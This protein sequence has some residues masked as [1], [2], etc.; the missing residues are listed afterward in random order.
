MTETQ[1]SRCGWLLA[2]VLIGYCALTL[3]YSLLTPAWEANDEP[4]HTANAEHILYNLSLYPLELHSEQPIPNRPGRMQ[5]VLWFESH[6]P[7]L[8]YLLLAG[9]Q[10][11]LGIPA[12]DPYLLPKSSWEGGDPVG[13][14]FSHD[15]DAHQHGQALVLRKLRLLSV[16]IGLVTVLICYRTASLAF[17]RQDIAVSAAAF[18]AFL[19]KF[20][21][22]N[23]TVTNDGLAVMF[24]ALGLWLL[25]AHLRR[26]EQPQSGHASYVLPAFLGLA[27]GAAAITKLNTLPVSGMLLVSLSFA[28][29]PWK[30]RFANVALFAACFL[31]V[32]GW[33]F[34]RNFDLYSDVLAEKASMIAVAKGVKHVIVP[35]D[36]SKLEQ[37]ADRYL[38]FAPSWFAD[39]CWY[40][41]SWN[42]F[43]PPPVWNWSMLAVAFLCLAIWL[44]SWFRNRSAVPWPI[45]L[46]LLLT[47]L[48]AAAAVAIIAK[49]T[50]QA[51]GRIAYVGL[52]AFAI[53]ATRGAWQAAPSRYR[54][55]GL[56]LWPALLLSLNAYA[57]EKFVWPFRGL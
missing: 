38:K 8:Y 23:A 26:A 24:S 29:L 27:C 1:G 51:E 13:L 30:R 42:Q 4:A 33:W 12:F 21:V 37:V 11:L 9:W 35:V 18:V 41:G 6:Q 52:T 5:L 50:Q 40:R 32:S 57:I 39:G 31:L 43:Y 2:L 3:T 17:H 44:G 36:F 46:S 16:F 25:L 14:I 45:Q 48:G 34:K 56:L 53:A 7:P 22:I 55:I 20:N 10:R 54:W 28:R 15:Y 47:I 19:P 49:N